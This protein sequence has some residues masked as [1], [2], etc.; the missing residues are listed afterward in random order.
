MCDSSQKPPVP[1]QIN[2]DLADAKKSAFVSINQ[3]P[4]KANQ[5][6]AH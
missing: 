4:A 1:T 5:G 3:R 2:A 6:I